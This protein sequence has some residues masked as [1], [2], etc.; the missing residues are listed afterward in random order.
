MDD[1]TTKEHLEIAMRVESKLSCEA[2]DTLRQYAVPPERWAELLPEDLDARRQL[3]L[4]LASEFL[5][6]KRVPC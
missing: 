2:I 6:R 1:G 5:A 3:L 4:A